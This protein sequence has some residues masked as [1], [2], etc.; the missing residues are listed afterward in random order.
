MLL[1]IWFD[2]LCRVFLESVSYVIF[3]LC[4]CSLVLWSF[5]SGLVMIFCVYRVK[6]SFLDI[7]MCV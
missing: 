7:F 3:P 6:V 4:I 5:V 1:Y 2:L